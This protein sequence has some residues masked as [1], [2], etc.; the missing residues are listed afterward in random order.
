MKKY[1]KAFSETGISDVPLVGGKNASLG[2]MISRLSGKGIPV[3]DGFSVTALGFQHFLSVNGLHEKL[4]EIL[5]KLDK[6]TYQNLK[7][8]GKAARELFMSG[9]LPEDLVSEIRQSYREL[10]GPNPIA[11]AV[12]SSATAE[13]LPHASFAG[14]H[15]SYLNVRGE[16]SLLAAVH[17][18][19]ASLYTDRAI[20]YREDNGFEHTKVSL[21]VGVQHMVR[22][23]TGCSG[24]CFTLEPESGFRDVIHISGVWGLGENIVQG[25]VTPD[26]FYVFKP[27]LAKGFYALLQKKLGEKEFLMQYG[28]E[29]G[30]PVK[31]IETPQDLR[32]Q[33]VL[34]DAEVQDLAKWALEIES[35]YQRPMDIE[36]AKDGETG[37]LYIIQA[38]PETVHSQ[39]NPLHVTE[40]HIKDKGKCLARG[41]AIGRKVVTGKARLL[42]SPAESGKLQAGDIVVT[43]LTSPDWD[44]ILKL[45]GG[46]IT[47]KGGRTSHASI[48]ARELGVPAV[49][50]CGNATESIRDGALITVSCSEGKTGF[51]YEG[52]VPFTETDIDFSSIQKPT[53]TKVMLIAGDPDKAYTLSF[54]PNDGVGLMRLEFIITHAVQVHPMALIRYDA[55][56]DQEAKN[57]IDKLARNYPDRTTYF[58]DK[59]AQGVATIAAAFYPKD[60]IVRMS[61]FKSNEYANLVGGRDFEPKEENP[62]I[63]FR[64]A[65]R[66]YHELYREGF[67]LECEAIRKVRDQM[68]L[69]NVKVMIPFCRTVEEG[70]KVIAQMKAFGLEQS[71]NGLEVYVMA[72]IPSN[73]VLA[74]QFA[75]LFDGFSIGSNDLTQLTLGIDRDSALVSNLFSEQNDA[76]T[77][78]IATVIQKARAAGKKIGLCGQAPSDFPEFA[79]FLV[80]QG[81][82]SISFNPDALLKGIEHIV[83]AER[84]TI[85]AS[86]KHAHSGL[87]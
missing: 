68:G 41:E 12:R 28:D 3:P 72:E 14:Q 30:T 58:V 20:K 16:E 57:T 62:M 15:E 24:V 45:A 50:G 1:I 80:Q 35:H 70:R 69:S 25:T 29:P 59:L 42:S 71:V 79:A 43:D 74:E 18:C 40:Y 86:A 64:G 38:R 7:E 39:V 75:E 60:V 83:Q 46:I 2:E 11:V 6:E 22:A 84:E 34:T 19:F 9:T 78:M 67:R 27:T 63:G 33:F 8:T 32:E 13:D 4:H 51:V 10:S 48:V 66:Y 54:Y 61:D 47:N 76:A 85:P 65:S 21:S 23:D 31:N 49:V 56:T 36:W 17:R 5:S 81:I 55:V 53:R 52:L 44:P 37:K 82:H 77:Y 26:E 73:V 87:S